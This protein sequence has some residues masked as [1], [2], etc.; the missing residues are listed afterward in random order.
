MS[1]VSLLASSSH[2]TEAMTTMEELG[3]LLEMTVQLAQVSSQ[4]SLANDELPWYSILE[5]SGSG[6]CLAQVESTTKNAGG[7]AALLGQGHSNDGTVM[8][9]QTGS[10]DSSSSL[11]PEAQEMLMLAQCAAEADAE[12]EGNCKAADDLQKL[13]DAQKAKVVAMKQKRQKTAV[14]KLPTTHEEAMAV[15]RNENIS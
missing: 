8:L 1:I 13:I 3:E 15:I 14:R 11:D 2:A 12:A 9:S 4:L 10:E 7:F 5:S 6:Q